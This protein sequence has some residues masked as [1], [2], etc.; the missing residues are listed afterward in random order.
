MK[1]SSRKWLSSFLGLT[2][3]CLIQTFYPSFGPRSNAAS[4]GWDIP[5]NPAGVDTTFKY[6]VAD[7]PISGEVRTI[8]WP[9]DYWAT[10]RDNINYRWDGV[11]NSLSPAEKVA[12]AFNLPNFPQNITRT[13]GIYGHQRKACDEENECQDLR[14]S[15]VCAKPRDSVGPKAGRCVPPWWGIGNGWT[16]AA[17]SEQ[18]P[19]HPVT[20]NG[21]SF[22]PG[23][24]EALL[25]Y[26][27][28]KNTTS[29]FISSRCNR[30]LSE[31]DSDS[32]GRLLNP[33]CR[34]MNPG[35]LFVV[36]SNMVGIRKLS[37]IEDRISYD[38]VWH[39][40]IRGYRVTNAVNGKLI[41][42][43]QAK[44]ISLLRSILVPLKPGNYPYNT[45][46]SRF[47]HV[48]MDMSYIIPPRPSRESQARQADLYTRTDSLGFILEA[49]S[50]GNV[51]GGEW[52][53]HS[54]QSHPDFV[55]WPVGKPQGSLHGLTYTMVKD[56]LD[57]ARGVVNRVPKRIR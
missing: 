32:Y 37:I 51:L 30:K 46:A 41:E 2:L 35:T 34:D 15:S 55:W 16:A 5:N 57:Q 12:Q 36:L 4:E 29:K 7:L 42:V 17:L 19:I 21:I 26:I 40:P 45:A 1:S 8:P 50:S 25:S 20:K 47:F 39:Q 48:E 13:V 9:S 43:S 14:D 11:Q 33:D 38:E 49:D 53:G 22:Y 56:L 6:N 10:V 52:L 27:Y 28:S 31:F 3:A 18:A 23:D 24:L 54:R 44:A